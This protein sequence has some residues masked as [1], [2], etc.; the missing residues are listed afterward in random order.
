MNATYRVSL[1][2]ARLPDADLAPFTQNVIDSLTGNASY[3]SS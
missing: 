2:F 3:H 1:G